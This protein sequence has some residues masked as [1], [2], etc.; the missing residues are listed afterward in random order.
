MQLF[1]I[2]CKLTCTYEEHIICF[3]TRSLNL[4]INSN[5]SKAVTE[6]QNKESLFYNFKNH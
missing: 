2:S 3:A 5:L 6:I 1:T 4:W